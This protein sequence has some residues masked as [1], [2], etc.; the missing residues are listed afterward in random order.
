MPTVNP[1]ILIW[2]RETA[3]FSVS[4]ASVVLGMKDGRRQRAIDRLA[5]LEAGTAEPSRSL[6]LKMA[7]KYRRPLLSFYL[8]SP[9][10][11]GD[12]GEDFRSVPDKQTDSE[13]LVDALL[14]DVRSRQAAVRD[15]LLDDDTHETLSFIGSMNTRDGVAEVLA[16]I[17]N[18]IRIDL[19]EYRAQASPEGA[20]A[21]LRERAEA[22]GIF[23]LLIGNL[24]SHHTA[25][26]VEAFR[27]F[28]LADTIAPFVVI[29]DQDAPAAWSF[30]LIHEL[31][32]LW[33]GRTGVSGRRPEMEIEKFCNDVAANFLLPPSELAT[34]G[35]DLDTP[36]EDVIKYI[37]AFAEE[38]H[39]SRSMVAYSLYRASKISESTWRAITAFF[40]AQWRKSRDAKRERQRD[41]RGPNFYVVRRHRLGHA[42]LRLI[43]RNL[44]EGT[45]TPTR[46]S[47]VLGVKP[48][49]V[50]PLLSPV[51]VPDGKAA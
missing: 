29:N 22:A 45:L 25:I 43:A 1:E 28:A 49:N 32:H 47:K 14:R 23:V 5:A 24:G 17:R 38:R 15:I 19:A 46:A 26:N 3:G 37:N 13:T 16:S 4:R 9:P 12:R 30:T 36:K 21:L 18:V 35:V 7:Q 42:L 44:T 48:R 11:R 2:A 39:L 50:A 31:T 27:G 10:K 20:F 8:P 41:A 40:L 33:L 51:Q 34:V 6:L